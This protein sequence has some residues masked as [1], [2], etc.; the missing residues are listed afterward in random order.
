M[1]LYL[2]YKI[3]DVHISTFHTYLP[4]T[5]DERVNIKKKNK[6]M[7]RQLKAYTRQ[8]DICTYVYIV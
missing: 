6:I 7:Y 8:H 4:K 3:P 2:K 1:I 5:N